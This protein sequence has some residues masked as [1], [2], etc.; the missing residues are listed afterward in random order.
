MI[1]SDT[2]NILCWNAEGIMSSIPYLMHCIEVHNISIC[3]VAEHWL[4]EFNMHFVSSLMA[5]N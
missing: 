4:R 5:D 3:G 1:D 2:L